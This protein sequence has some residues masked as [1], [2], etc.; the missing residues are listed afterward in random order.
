M[1]LPSQGFRHAVTL[2]LTK[3]VRAIPQDAKPYSITH[4]LA[5]L[6]EE[7]VALADDTRAPSD[8]RAWLV[9]EYGRRIERF[10][11]AIDIFEA[12]NNA[13]RILGRVGSRPREIERRDLFVIYAPE[14]R[15]PI[16]APLAIELTKRRISVAFSDYEV[17]T[18][19]QLASALGHGTTHHAAGVLLWTKA[20]ERVTAEPPCETDR[21]RVL[22]NPEAPATLTALAHWASSSGFD[23]WRDD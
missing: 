11:N 9:D 17:A 23:R 15:L 18:Q 4:A 8:A 7:L 2:L 19:D 16:A 14:D 20:F 10:S 22:L 3:G 1:W 13:A 21:F 6:T 5:R 12:K